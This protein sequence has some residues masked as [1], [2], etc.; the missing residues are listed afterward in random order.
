M[1]SIKYN[2]GVESKVK[3]FHTGSWNN[4]ILSQ[5]MRCRRTCHIFSK[6][7]KTHNMIQCEHIVEAH[8][9][10]CAPSLLFARS[11]VLIYIFYLI[12]EQC[13]HANLL[14]FM[15]LS[16]P[17]AWFGYLQGIFRYLNVTSL[18]ILLHTISC[19]NDIFISM[20]SDP[21]STSNEY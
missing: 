7:I 11:H 8:F 2:V 6:K 1:Y 9:S 15:K 16:L 20:S 3:N 18:L 13:S 19:Y 4:K 10:L 12:F 14:L 21:C 5:S 17:F